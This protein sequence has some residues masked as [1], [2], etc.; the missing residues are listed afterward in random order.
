MVKLK[1]MEGYKIILSFLFFSL[2]FTGAFWVVPQAA[3][4][5]GE[6]VLRLSPASGSFLVGSTFDL[7]ILLD[8]KGSAVNTIEVDLSFPSDKIQ[9][10][11]P[12][13]GKS[14][15]QVWPAPPVFSNREGR[16]YFVGGIPSP[17]IVTSDGVVLTLTFRVVSPG[18]AQIGFQEKTSVLAND[19]RGT[20]ILGQKPS[21]FYRFSVPP[22]QGPE[23][24][25]PTHPDQE[26]WYRDSNP[27]FVWPRSSF[28][29]G[30][31]YSIDHDPSGFP[32]TNV[33]GTSPTASYQN[34]ENG[35]SYFHLRERAGGVWG[36]VSH[37]VAKID[38][39][40]PASFRLNIS[41]GRRTTNRNPIFRFFTT[42]S[43]SGFDHFEMK[44][45]PL[46]QGEVSESLFFEVNSPYQSPTLNPGRYQV[47]V[48]ALD[49]AGS[50]RDETVSL[51]ILGAFNQFIT[52][53]GID[54]IFIFLPWFWM[55]LL[56]LGLLVI[57]LILF[58]LLWIYHRRHLGRS[59]GEEIKRFLRFF[60]K[61][62]PP[63]AALLMILGGYYFFTSGLPE[64]NLSSVLNANREMRIKY[65]FL[66][67][68]NISENSISDWLSAKDLSFG[69]A[70]S[71][72]ENKDAPR[73]NVSLNMD[74][75]V[76]RI[77][78]WF[79]FNVS[80]FFQKIGE[81]FWSVKDG[82]LD[83]FSEASLPRTTR[84]R[85]KIEW[86]SGFTG[87]SDFPVKIMQDRP[88]SA[89][90]FKSGVKT[91]AEKSSVH[92]VAKQDYL[93]AAVLRV[94]DWFY[95]DFSAFLGRIKAFFIAIF[96]SIKDAF[97]NFFLSV[98]AIN[99]AIA[100][101]RQPDPVLAPSINVAPQEYYPLDEAIYL[102]GKAEPKNKV[103]IYFEKISGGVQ[104]ISFEVLANSNGEW[105]LSQKLELSS[106]E[107]SVRAR[108]MSDPPSD[109]SNPRIIKSVVSG[110]LIGGLKIK[111]APVVGLLSI[112]FLTAGVLLVYSMLRVRAIQRKSIADNLRE[113]NKRLEK[114][115][116]E[117]EKEMIEHTVSDNF[118]E[119]RKKLAG[120]LE[121]LE[122]KTRLGGALNSE[123]EEHREKLL[124]ELRE[125]EEEIDRKLK[126]I[127]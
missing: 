122:T 106:G 25:S 95:F 12:S 61:G 121:H 23:I 74:A 98:H 111:Y 49:R 120:E 70:P 37:F 87:R 48:R 20:N 93:N 51:N 109:W 110:F 126:Q 85:P 125:A 118:A 36:G 86:M 117:K 50:T 42:D 1:V 4:S 41:P 33:E 78:N 84:S 10:A 13:V 96:S 55:L 7:S 28:A 58:L 115:L 105:F 19:G 32:D 81:F 101:G 123:E 46:S 114:E 89:A 63:T 62:A 97:V 112:G 99:Y 29:D 27:V 102:E 68:G 21:S 103:Q 5:A 14:I 52:P 94:G 3:L 92:G 54:L 35:I 18:D 43:L 11:S 91:V 104:P 53:E 71:S 67:L 113:K 6:A 26:K 69:Q 116:R 108:V 39:D 82:F 66:G 24:S 83:I 17:G 34:V 15:I 90:N 88:S 2:I 16:I 8:T 124:R 77:G 80:I 60:R 64:R 9:I 75:G 47:I 56:V 76:F 100:Q 72:L 30:Y 44:I 31:S 65:E 79:Y 40:P 38:D 107:W 22:P 45:I 127:A 73:V 59:L 57:L 119:I